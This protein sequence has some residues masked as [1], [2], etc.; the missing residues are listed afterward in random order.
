MRNRGD[1]KW[2]SGAQTG[3]NCCPAYSSFAQQ[4]DISSTLQV[5]EVGKGQL[6][7]PNSSLEFLPATGHPCRTIVVHLSIKYSVDHFQN[8]KRAYYHKSCK[9][10]SILI[11][12][13]YTLLLVITVSYNHVRTTKLTAELCLNRQILLSIIRIDKNHVNSRALTKAILVFAFDPIDNAR[14]M[15]P[16][17]YNPGIP[18]PSSDPDAPQFV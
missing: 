6:V 13:R 3:A 2:I 16:L 12:V 1:I 7:F 5:T 14:Y 4:T 8:P 9:S 11:F 15:R 17:L 10:F 18:V